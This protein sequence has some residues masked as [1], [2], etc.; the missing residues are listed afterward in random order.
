MRALTVDQ[1]E[2]R[3]ADQLQQQLKAAGKDKDEVKG[4]G[5]RKIDLFGG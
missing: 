5:H 1:G 2:K 4:S 3:W